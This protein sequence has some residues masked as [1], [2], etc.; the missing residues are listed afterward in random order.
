[1]AS[2]N[3]ISLKNVT[4]FLDHEGAPIA[5]GN[6][7]VENKKIGFWAQDSWGG[8]NIIDL[9]I[10]Y[11][12]HLLKKTII[13]LNKD[14]SFHG[15]RN[16]GSTY[17]I[18]YDIENL[19]SDLLALNDHEKSFYEARKENYG[20]IMV[21]TDGYQDI[22]WKLP[23]GHCRKSDEELLSSMKDAISRSKDK[24]LKEDDSITHKIS[25]YRNPEDF[26]IGTPIT[27]KEISKG[28][29]LDTLIDAADKS[30]QNNEKQ[31][32]QKHERH[33]I[34][35]NYDLNFADWE[36]D[37]AMEYPNESDDGL[38]ERMVELNDEYLD[39]ECANLNIRLNQPILV[40][41]DLGLWNGRKDGY[42][43]IQSG[44]IKDCLYSDTDY[45]TW[46]V[47]KQ[48]DLRADAYHHDGTNHYLYRVWKDDVSETQ[49][50][51]LK[52]KIYNGKA[53]RADI[54]RLTKRLGDDI[55]KVYGWEINKQRQ[56]KDR[57]R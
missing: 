3:G 2:I 15:T 12:E 47:D 19:C 33:L 46:Y 55:A 31:S 10:P 48:G 43:E 49:K 24:L 1:M 18:D 14:K 4:T 23:Q 38:Y 28:K 44:N 32:V 13:T 36:D 22:T 29:S 53:T 41:A 30:R 39:D 45:T 5:Q 52:D 42:K 8:P 11:Y 54:T 6:L 16:D 26:E 57:E 34:W 51:N 25:I 40:I 37:L 7:Y 35:T 20:G 50:D 56:P 17:T 27:L 21:L 9:D